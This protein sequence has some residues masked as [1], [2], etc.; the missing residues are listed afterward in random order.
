MN[1]VNMLN[2]YSSDSRDR[3]PTQW[4]GEPLTRYS[5]CAQCQCLYSTD[6]PTMNVVNMLDD[7]GAD[8]RDR[9]PAQWDGKPSS[10]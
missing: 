7:Y 8:P 10:N 4:D 9:Y 1:V 3:Y 2:D 5:P 6:L